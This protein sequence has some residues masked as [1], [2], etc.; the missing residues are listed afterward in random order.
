MS[1]EF[2]LERGSGNVFR[3]LGLPSPELRQAKAILA[4]EIVKTL[5]ER[6]WSTR[7]AQQETGVD[8]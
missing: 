8:H 1:D 4:A 3:D 6:Q 7:K 5:D 2:E